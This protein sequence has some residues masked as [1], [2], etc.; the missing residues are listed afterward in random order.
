MLTER[1]SQILNA[2][3]DEYIHTALPVSSGMVFDKGIFDVS[4][5]TI[6]NE[7]ADLTG[8]GYLAQP[9]TSAGRVPT[10]KGYR[11]FVDILISEGSAAGSVKRDSTNKKSSISG[12]KIMDKARR[13]SRDTNDLVIFVDE[14]DGEVKYF[15]LRKVFE[16]PEFKT[17]EAVVSMLG[18][19]ER[20]ENYVEAVEKYLARDIEIFIGSENPFFENTEYGM[21]SARINN[22]I[23]AVLG[24]MR[25]N[26][27][28]NLSL[29]ERI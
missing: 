4:C 3:V 15:G 5:P 23:I 1:Q 13:V 19:L 10:E 29:L 6:R 27:K 14:E 21:I 12:E 25:M 9:H 7:M 24:P 18:E 8:M 17:H 26:Y 2:I 28:I 11:L 20:F 16:N 22:N